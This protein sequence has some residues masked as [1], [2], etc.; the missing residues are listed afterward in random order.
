[1]TVHFL[2]RDFAE[3]RIRAGFMAV[4]HRQRLKSKDK[5]ALS[6]AFSLL[7]FFSLESCCDRNWQDAGWAG[8]PNCDRRRSAH[9]A[10]PHE[11]SLRTIAWGHL[12]PR[13]AHYVLFSP[14]YFNSAERGALASFVPNCT[15]PEMSYCL[16][17]NAGCGADL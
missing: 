9:V 15:H 2:S 6:R 11:S 3:H 16:R 10:W 8:R 17:R 1:M 12:L 14:G 7:G 5:T 13:K 4:A